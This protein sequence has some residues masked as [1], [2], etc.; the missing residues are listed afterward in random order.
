MRTLPYALA[1]LLVAGLG[2]T[3][4]ADAQPRWGQRGAYGVQDSAYENGYRD[5]LAEGA[6]DARDG[7][8]HIVGTHT[9]SRVDNAD[10][11][12]AISAAFTT[13]PVVVSD[14]NH[15]NETA[16]TYP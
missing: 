2:W 5:G 13:T 4:P 12:A 11:M 6:R 3:A 10:P 1:T 8:H 7:R 15:R 14:A 9:L 16:L